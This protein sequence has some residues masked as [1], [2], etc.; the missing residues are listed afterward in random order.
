MTNLKGKTLFITGATRG[1][2]FAIA[3]RAAEET[4]PTIAAGHP[5]L[6]ASVIFA[7]FSG[8]PKLI[9]NAIIGSAIM[10]PI[11]PTQESA[12]YPSNLSLIIYCLNYSFNL[13]YWM[14]IF[15][16]T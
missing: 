14:T 8:G 13:H 10:L 5:R 12:Q 7:T 15:N 9:I 6:M 11:K 2:G 3:K 16:A 4:I 1:I